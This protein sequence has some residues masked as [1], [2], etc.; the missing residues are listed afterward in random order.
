MGCVMN[1]IVRNTGTDS[2]GAEKSL[3]GFVPV[4]LPYF[5]ELHAIMSNLFI[6]KY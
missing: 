1:R 3:P 6:I 5:D 4:F 2:G